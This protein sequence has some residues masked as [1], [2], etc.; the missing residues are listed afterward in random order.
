MPSFSEHCTKTIA[1][2][3]KPFEE[4]HLWLDE[5]AGKPPYGMRH[6]KVRHHLAGIEQVRKLW[7]NQAAEA[8]RI[9]IIADLKLEGWNENDPFPG[10][11]DDYKRMGLF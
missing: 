11:E 10:S 8:A 3:G 5:F 9:H 4:V 7:G 6:R 1:A 2:L